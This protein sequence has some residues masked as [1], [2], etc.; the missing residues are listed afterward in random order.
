LTPTFFVA[1]FYRAITLQLMGQSEA[2]IAAMRRARGA[3]TELEGQALDASSR[4]YVESWW[5]HHPEL[6]VMLAAVQ[7]LSDATRRDAP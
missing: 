6:P 5:R 3:N 4:F 1:H 2:A 7:K